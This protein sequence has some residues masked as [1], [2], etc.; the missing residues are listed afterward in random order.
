MSVKPAIK[1]SLSQA[2]AAFNVWWLTVNF[3]ALRTPA[4][5]AL[6]GILLWVERV[7]NVLSLIANFAVQLMSAKTAQEAILL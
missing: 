2:T 5:R 1:D 6:Q 4:R 7:L 3:A